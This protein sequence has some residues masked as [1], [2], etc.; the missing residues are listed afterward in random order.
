MRARENRE[1]KSGRWDEVRSFRA[2]LETR[3]VN[4]MIRMGRI[5]FLSL[6]KR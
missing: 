3:K 6:R 2:G 4:Q 5:I 1:Q